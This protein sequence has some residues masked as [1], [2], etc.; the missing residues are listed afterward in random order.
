ML[1]LKLLVSYRLYFSFFSYGFPSVV[2]PAFSTPAYSTP[3]VYSWLFHSCVFNSCIFSAP[4]PHNTNNCGGRAFT[5]SAQVGIFAQSVSFFSVTSRTCAIR[6]DSARNSG[7]EAVCE[8]PREKGDGF[9]RWWKIRRHWAKFTKHRLNSHVFV[10][11]RQSSL[12]IVSTSNKLGP[13]SAG[14]SAPQGRCWL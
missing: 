2:A 14:T 8:E 3:A 13:A 4:P 7:N 5:R 12:C 1:C 6:K 9:S 10:V 11:Q